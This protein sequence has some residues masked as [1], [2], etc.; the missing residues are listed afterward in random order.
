MPT[1]PHPT[2]APVTRA[3]EAIYPEPVAQERARNLIVILN[4]CPPDS[5]CDLWADALDTVW[6]REEMLSDQTLRRVN[7]LSRGARCPVEAAT[8]AA[9][10]AYADAVMKSDEL[11][12]RIALMQCGVPRDLA[13]FAETTTTEAAA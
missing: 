8:V 2:I 3:L 4:T 1:T 9:L 5:L 10:R 13:G 7:R 6:L 11:T 12:L